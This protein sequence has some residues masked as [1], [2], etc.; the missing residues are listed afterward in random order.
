MIED[1]RFGK[2]LM[3][4]GSRHIILSQ[5][6]HLFGTVPDDIRRRLERIYDAKRLERIAGGLLEVKDLKQLKQLIGSNGKPISHD[7]NGFKRKGLARASHGVS[8]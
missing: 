3:G 7:R 8:R 5:I 4:M 6:E 1:T 2:E